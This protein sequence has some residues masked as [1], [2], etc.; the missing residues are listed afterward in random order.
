LD[1]TWFELP[2]G[3]AT[4]F[5]QSGETYLAVVAKEPE[6][7]PYYIL[8]QQYIA[9]ELNFLRGADP[10]AVQAEFDAATALFGQYTPDEAAA[11]EGQARQE[12]IDLASVL[13]DYN[14]GYTGPGYCTG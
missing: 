4:P 13:D 11:L 14:N 10:A 12:W 3:P 7:N 6:G 9:A 5:F 8:A 2:N 1:T